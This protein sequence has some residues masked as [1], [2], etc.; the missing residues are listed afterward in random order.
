MAGGS[1]VSVLRAASNQINIA[2]ASTTPHL[3][4]ID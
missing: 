4:Q 1:D 2:K 3:E